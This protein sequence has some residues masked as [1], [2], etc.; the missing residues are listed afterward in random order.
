MDTFKGPWLNLLI[1]FYF[2]VFII[3]IILPDSCE[4]GV[5]RSIR[6]PVDIPIANGHSLI[7]HLWPVTCSQIGTAAHHTDHLLYEPR[8]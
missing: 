6:E 3:I 7:T 2:T 5:I 1:L 4:L 8:T